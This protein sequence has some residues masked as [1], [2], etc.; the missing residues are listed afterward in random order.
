MIRLKE[1]YKEQYS[2]DRIM[3]TDGDKLSAFKKFRFERLPHQKLLGSYLRFGEFPAL[4]SYL[5]NNEYSRKYLSDGIIDKIL[6]KDIRLFEVEKEEEIF[7]LYKICC[8][9]MA[10]MINLKNVAAETGLSYPTIKKYLSV[11]KKT[12]LI[13]ALSLLLL[14]T[15]KLLS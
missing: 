1:D 6:H 13:T 9:N 4:L 14:I 15:I 5:D 2:F 8:S 11:L 12:F 10:Q 3:K 7:S